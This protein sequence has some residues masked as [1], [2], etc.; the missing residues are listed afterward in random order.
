VIFKEYA[1]AAAQLSGTRRESAD[2]TKRMALREGD[3]LASL[4]AREYR[5]PAQWRVI[6]LANH[7]EDPEHIQP[8]TLLELP[9]LY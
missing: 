5:S 3:T 9:P 1:T 8:G 6:A 4:A 7:I 2:H